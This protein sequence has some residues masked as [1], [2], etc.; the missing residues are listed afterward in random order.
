[1]SEDPVDFS[2]RTADETIDRNEHSQ[3]QFSHVDSWVYTLF[4]LYLSRTNDGGTPRHQR[5]NFSD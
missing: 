1:M 4:A 3:Y 5:K 2:V